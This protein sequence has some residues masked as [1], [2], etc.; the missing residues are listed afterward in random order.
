MAFGKKNPT[1]PPINWEACAALLDR[2]E[3][4]TKDLNEAL[5][6]TTQVTIALNTS[7][8]RAQAEARTRLEKK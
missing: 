2:M 6:K 4:A 5:R 3:K 7:L 1:P 8:S